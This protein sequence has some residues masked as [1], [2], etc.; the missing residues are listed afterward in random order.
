MSNHEHEATYHGGDALAEIRGRATKPVSGAV[1]GDV[2]RIIWTTYYFGADSHWHNARTGDRE[3]NE[4]LSIEMEASQGDWEWLGSQASLLAAVEA[5][6]GLHRRG[7]ES[8]E[9][10]PH[11][12][13]DGPCEHEDKE[14]PYV[15]ITPCY[16]CSVTGEN[17][18]EW[19][20]ATV[21]A[22]TGAL[23]GAL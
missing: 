7:E 20:C 17:Y 16:E 6:L 2:I 4:T 8:E 19:P 18:F 13:I 5:V 10:L 1:F 11:S 22:V 23:G 21:R 3:T 12:C 9:V 14:C 15:T